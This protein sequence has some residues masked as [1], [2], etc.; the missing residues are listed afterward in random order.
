[1]KE[2]REK[3]LLPEAI[4]PF[5]KE[6][7]KKHPQAQC[8][9]STDYRLKEE[10]LSDSHKTIVTSLPTG[11]WSAP[12]KQTSKDQKEVIRVFYLAQKIHHKAPSFEEMM[13]IIKNEL[14]Q[15]AALKTSDEYLSKLRKHYR[16]DSKH[17]AASLP[18]EYQPF[19]I[20]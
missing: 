4:D 13:P 8:S 15:K 19:S 7:Q 1:M 10:E 3:N 9:L 18:D 20:Q 16:F 11:S 12:T 2:I 6:L 17:L 14:L 5:L